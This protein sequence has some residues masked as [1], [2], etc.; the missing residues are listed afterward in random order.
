M[1]PHVLLD[2]YVRD[3]TETLMREAGNERLAQLARRPD[4]PI[5]RLIAGWLVSAAEWVEG[6]PQGSMARA[7]A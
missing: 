5:R 3:H 7:Q 1:Y 4:R 2:F 6:R